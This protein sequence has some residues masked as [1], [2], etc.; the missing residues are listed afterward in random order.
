MFEKLTTT[1]VYDLCNKFQWFTHGTCEQ[2]EKMFD[3]VR[4]ANITDIIFT[5]KTEKLA[6]M[7]WICSDGFT[8]DEIHHEIRQC[9]AD[10]NGLY[11]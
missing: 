3:Y 8:L 10:K 2:Y 5:D 4:E 1:D 11:I 6:T 7:I 9:F